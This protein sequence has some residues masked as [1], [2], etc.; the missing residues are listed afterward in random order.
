[1]LFPL[2]R[3]TTVRW[4]SALIT[5]TQLTDHAPTSPPGKKREKEYL[6]LCF[7]HILGILTDFLC[8]QLLFSILKTN[9]AICL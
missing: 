8:K 6:F 1:M 4:Q 3:Y 9:L 5:A 2:L 7:L